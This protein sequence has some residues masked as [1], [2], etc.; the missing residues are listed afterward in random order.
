M[1]G[2]YRGP[3]VALKRSGSGMMLSPQS[4]SDSDMFGARLARSALGQSLPPGGGF[5]MRTG[6]AERVQVIWPE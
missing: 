4:S 1:G 6:S 2:I 5:L 3:V